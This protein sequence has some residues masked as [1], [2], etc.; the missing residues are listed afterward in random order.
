MLY[1][2]LT[3]SVPFNSKTISGVIMAHLTQP[4]PELPTQV[5]EALRK[6]VMRLLAKDPAERFERAVPPS[7][8]HSRIASPPVAMSQ[9]CG[10]TRP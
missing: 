10:A 7:I 6:I 8:A 5:P 1:E 4:P 2:L 9:R 3:G